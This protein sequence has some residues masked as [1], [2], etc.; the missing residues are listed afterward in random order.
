[1]KEK[2]DSGCGY[3][4]VGSYAVDVERMGRISNAGLVVGWSQFGVESLLEELK[5]Y[6]RVV[7]IRCLWCQAA[8][9]D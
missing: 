4:Y 7:W 9:L 6:V 2:A 5:G 8:R 3:G 1:M